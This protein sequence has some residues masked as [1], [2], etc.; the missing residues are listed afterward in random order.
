MSFERRSIRLHETF[1]SLQLSTPS[2]KIWLVAGAI[3]LHLPCLSW[4]KNLFA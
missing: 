2:P 1:G 4:R 3:R